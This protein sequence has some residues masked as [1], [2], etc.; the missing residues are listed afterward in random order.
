MDLLFIMGLSVIMGVILVAMGLS[1]I[2]F[3]LDSLGHSDTYG[4]RTADYYQN[5]LHRLD[6]KYFHYRPK[7][8]VIVS[9]KQWATIEE[10]M[11]IKLDEAKNNGKILGYKQALVEIQDKVKEEKTKT[12]PSSPYAVLDIESKAPMA[13]IEKKYK[14]LLQIYDPKNFITLDKA[15]TELAEIRRAQI[16]RAW[17]QVNLGIKPKSLSGGNF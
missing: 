9:K 6:S 8:S 13:E 1:F 16:T 7:G 15:F 14:Y 5:P 4:N 12:F 3:G 11:G 2:D 17:N 10:N